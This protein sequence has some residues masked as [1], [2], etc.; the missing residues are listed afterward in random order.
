MELGSAPLSPWQNT[1][2][3]TIVDSVKDNKQW[4][5]ERGG[6]RGMLPHLKTVLEKHYE[7]AYH[8]EIKGEDVDYFVAKLFADKTL[9]SEMNK[10]ANGGDDPNP[11]EY[12]FD[13]PEKAV[14]DAHWR[15]EPSDKVLTAPDQNPENVEA[16]WTRM[17]VEIKKRK[18]P[19]EG[20]PDDIRNIP[21]KEIDKIIVTTDQ[22]LRLGVMIYNNLVDGP[23]N[24]KGTKLS[25]FGES[26]TNRKTRN[27]K[28]TNIK[29]NAF[30]LIQD[31][32]HYNYKQTTPGTGST[33]DKTLEWP[34]KK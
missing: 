9:M 2:V 27:N 29:E 15:K 16:T 32:D 10:K 33:T 8:D 26:A 4:L 12:A 13:I 19:E 34:M 6:K 24:G 20:E 11:I 3:G 5:L 14:T 28:S 1:D 22:L 18:A 17:K 23:W 25:D 21:S 7:G 31:S 30:S